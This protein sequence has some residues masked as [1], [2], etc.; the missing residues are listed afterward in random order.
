LIENMR[1]FPFRLKAGLQR[2][3]CRS[4]GFSRNRILFASLVIG[5]IVVSTSFSDDAL[6]SEKVAEHISKGWKINRPLQVTNLTQAY[7]FQDNVVALLSVRQGNPCGYKAALTSAALQKRFNYDRPV[8]GIVMQNMLLRDRVLLDQNF[9]PRP[10]LE[11][12]LMVMIKDES[13]NTAETYD[14]VIAAI[15]GIH[16]VI[17]LADLRFAEGTAIN[18]L[19]LTA[20]NAGA[21][22]AVVGD[23]LLVTGNATS[24]VER[25]PRV[26]ASVMDKQGQVI[27]T[28]TAERLLGHP[29]KVVLW[30]RDEVKSRGGY[31]KKGDVLWLGSLTDPLPVIPGESYQVLFTGLMEYPVNVR[32]QSAE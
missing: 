9:S 15:E 24:L 8:L 26:Q 28:G 18:P 22:V 5:N 3:V 20:I 13:I 27:A 4:S 23:P 31:L 2:V 25:L 32:K 29:L 6:T 7:E 21:N 30:V 10:V 16:P 11:A 19:W 12:D 14:Q 1:Q 17:E